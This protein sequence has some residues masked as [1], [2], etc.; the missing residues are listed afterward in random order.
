MNKNFIIKTLEECKKWN[1]GT[2]ISFRYNDWELILRKEESIYQFPF[3]ISGKK[4]GTLET[5]SR[6][7][8]SAEAAF[9]HVLNR[10]NENANIRN[11]YNTLEEA[12]TKIE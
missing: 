5:W 7:Y 9:L 6:R 12:L 2:V 8:I 1:E 3:S 4:T 11:K 10:F